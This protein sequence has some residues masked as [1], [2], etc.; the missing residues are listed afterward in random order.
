VFAPSWIDPVGRR[1]LGDLIGV[2]MAGRMDAARYARIWEV[3]EEGAR[4]PETTGLDPA[5]ERSFGELTLRRYQQRPAEVVTDFVSAFRG[6]RSVGMSV[7]APQ[8][9]LEEVGFEPHRCVVLVPRPDRTVEITYPGVQLGAELVGHAGLGDVFTRRDVREP[10]RLQVRVDGRVV[11]DVRFGVDDGW[12]RFAAPTHPGPAE[13]VF[14]ATAVGRGARD[15]RICFA[16][17]ARR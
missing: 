14:A 2:D 11:A 15:R 8:V 4:A 3:A 7:G 5:D 1:W 17:V 6:A 12:V 10:G 13:V 16:A 9:G